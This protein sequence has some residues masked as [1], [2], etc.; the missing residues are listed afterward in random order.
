MRYNKHK[1]TMENQDQQNIQP[2]YDFILNQPGSSPPPQT[3]LQTAGRSRKKLIIVAVCALVLV[4]AMAAAALLAPKSQTSNTD[5]SS[6]NVPPAVNPVDQFMKA[7]KAQDY[8]QAA[9]L[10][11]GGQDTKERSAQN[12]KTNFDAVNTDGCTVSPLVG[13]K[14]SSSSDLTCRAKDNSFG[15]TMH[16]KISQDADTPLIISYTIETRP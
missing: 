5:V 6:A 1:F 10:L 15:F 3:P 11:P 8:A 13:N 7:V 14:A 9:N 16:F 12:T 2:D 4:V